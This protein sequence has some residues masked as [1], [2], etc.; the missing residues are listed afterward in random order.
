MK[1]PLSWVRDFVDL[2]MPILELA[3][4]LTL[5]GLE[6]TEIRAVGLEV[7]LPGS[8]AKAAGIGS[9]A[10]VTGLAWA[11]DKIVVGE[12]RQVM[13]HPNADRLVLCRLFDGRQEHTVLT[14]APNLFS[15]KG[16]G[17]LESPLKVAYALE[18]AQLF[19]GHQPGWVVMTL[20]PAKIRG[21]ES[22]SM[23]CSEKELGISEDHEGII[24]LDEQ[25]PVGEALA[26]YMGDIVLDI[27]LTPNVARD[28]NM[29][30][31]AREI[32]ALFDVPLREPSGEVEWTGA[33][34]E[35]RV[36]IEIGVPELNPR[37]VLGLVEGVSI[38]ASPYEVQRRLRLAGMRP[39][40]NIVDATNY[41][42]LEVGQ[43]LHAFDY[44]VLVARA[45]GQAPTLMTRQAEPDEKLTTLDGVD[46]HLEAFTVLVTDTAGPLSIAG[47]MG[48]AESE[49]GPQTVNV[50][51]EGASWNFINIRQTLGSQKL[52]SEAAYRFSRGVHPAMAERGVRQGLEYMRRWA[53]GVVAEGLVDAYPRP[54]DPIRVETGPADVRRWLGVDMTAEAMRDL[55]ERLG[56]K[57]EPSGPDKLAVEPPD[58]RLDIGGGVIGRADVMEEIARLYGY[59]RIPETLLADPLPPQVRNRPAEVVESLRDQL[60]DMGLQEIVTYR[61]TT[62]E[63][64]ARVR[65]PGEA[66]DPAAYLALANPISSD[67]TVMRHSLLASVLG[68]L[69]RNRN[70]RDRMAVFEIGPVFF[71]QADME[72]PQESLRLAL[73][74]SGPILPG[75]W[76]HDQAVENMGFF[77]VKGLVEALFDGLHLGGMAY[78]AAPHPSLHPGR[79]AAVT[80]NGQPVGFVGELHPLVAEA[81]GYRERP[82]AVCELNLHSL[83]DEI[84]E[85]FEIEPIPAFP[86][87][88]EDLA[89][90]VD[91][92]TPAGD[93]AQAIR[94]AGGEMVVEVRLFD[95]FQGEQ[96]GAGKK[97]LAYSVVYQAPDRTLTDGDVA[98]VRQAIIDRL[99]KELGAVLR[100]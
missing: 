73:A 99:A 39:I 4:R 70:L 25:A 6:V 30:G 27:D 93:V 11:R 97:S 37:F 44:D 66:P 87:V 82:V 83:L 92:G 72:L 76:L 41:A 33:P 12:I 61:M 75:T 9:E 50:L 68:V 14:G 79:S 49:V 5:A 10:M 80:R 88:L 47:V 3:H 51:L 95:V 40:N 56:F 16:Q 55:L 90:V 23:V 21:V 63:A 29:L 78:Q 48:G 62:P 89:F 54:P 74:V 86:P 94:R 45:G 15:L 64:E 7:A 32:S 38:H 57:V 84:P 2:D 17:P 31:V 36:A 100:S 77:Q 58:H 91:D 98:A 24:L 46:R 65:A 1:V 69:A 34:I 52:S 81:Y 67:M 19:D 53:G 26:D 22:T 43:P 96:I 59:D 13:P 60:V 85:R 35:G 8:E 20:K 28:S 71:A 42:M 18:G